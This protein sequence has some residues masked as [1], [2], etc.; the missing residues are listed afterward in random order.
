MLRVGIL[1]IAVL[2]C[3]TALAA[4]APADELPP[5]KRALETFAAERQAN[6][7][8]ADKSADP[9]RPVDAETDPPPETGL[10]G[11]VNAPVLGAIFTPT[12]AWA[13]WTD[14]STYVQVF[15]GDTP[16]HPGRGAMFVLTRPGIGDG[17]HIDPNGAPTALF[18]DPP[19]PGGP[20]TI[21]A[22]KGGKLIVRNQKGK[23]YAF[24]PVSAQFEGAP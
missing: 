3:A 5:A 23:E 2:A 18:V 20:L 21:V 22:E 16:E 11:M 12:S 1:G 15:A 17:A 14:S 4:C 6:A 19:K 8:R 10:L 24:D 13:G 7:P 9:G